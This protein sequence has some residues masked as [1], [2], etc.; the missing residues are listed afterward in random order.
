[1][2]SYGYSSITRCKDPLW[3]SECLCIS[4]NYKKIKGK[5]VERLTAYKRTRQ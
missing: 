4:T 2:L 3:S 1:M 5:S